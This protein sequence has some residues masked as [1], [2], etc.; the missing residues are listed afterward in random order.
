MHRDAQASTLPSPTTAT[1]RTPC[2]D[3]ALFATALR[4]I[5]PGWVS[6]EDWLVGQIER[7][8]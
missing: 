4:G 7:L 5:L 3:E 2:P 6:L 8:R 1:L